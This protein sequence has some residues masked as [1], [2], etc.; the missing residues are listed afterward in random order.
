MTGAVLLGVFVVLVANYVVALIVFARRGLAAN[1]LLVILLTGTTGAGL[2]AVF[3]VLA[4]DSSRYVDVAL[5]F[6]GTAAIAAAVRSG[7]TT[8]AVPDS[9]QLGSARDDHA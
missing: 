5:V 2:A 8:S 6:T 7:I 3:A 9:G 4:E 1:W